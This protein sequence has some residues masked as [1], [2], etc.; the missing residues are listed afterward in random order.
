MKKWILPATLSLLCTAAVIVFTESYLRIERNILAL[1][2]LFILFALLIR[3]VAVAFRFIRLS[4]Q[5]Q[6]TSPSIP[7]AP[8]RPA[9]RSGLSDARLPAN[10]AEAEMLA[11]QWLKQATDCVKIINT[12]K[13]PAT[14]FERYDFFLDTLE[15]LTYCER[16]VHF[17]GTPPSSQ[18]HTAEAEQKEQTRLFILRYAQNTRE[19]MY[20]LATPRGKLN[21]AE[22]FY[23]TLT[24]Y[25]DRIDAE[26]IQLYTDQYEL[27]KQN[28]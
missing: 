23:N 11:T 7:L 27:L 6:T 19:K 24:E 28:I 17:K 5:S 18:L 10:K 9:F 13:N 1:V 26:N 12:T 3:L 25:S 15:R 20:Q 22:A 16:W 4:P 14:F 2:G 21:K 8:S